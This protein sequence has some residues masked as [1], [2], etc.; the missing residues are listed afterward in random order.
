MKAT[1]FRNL[2]PHLASP[3]TPSLAPGGAS[4]SN[5]RVT[6][7]HYLKK[8]KN[9]FLEENGACVCLGRWEGDASRHGLESLPFLLAPRRGAHAAAACPPPSLLWFCSLEPDIG[10][11]FSLPF[12]VPQGVSD[13]LGPNNCGGNHVPAGSR[14][15]H[16][17]RPGTGG[18]KALRTDLLATACLPAC[19]HWPASLPSSCGHLFRSLWTRVPCPPHLGP[20]SLVHEGVNLHGGRRQSKGGLS[21]MVY[22]AL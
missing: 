22:S 19:P 17:A 11:S 1:G 5:L 3:L 15:C 13:G 10:G 9:N 14:S 2:G 21:R 4:D 8:T 7:S 20:C 18:R 16:R 12:H 6:F